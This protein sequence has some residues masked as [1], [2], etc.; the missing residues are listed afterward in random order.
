MTPKEY[1]QQYRDAVRK[2]AAAQDHLDE[3]RSM[4][5]RITPNY[6]SEGGGTH[7]TGDKLGAAVARILDAESRVSDE[8]E[9]LEATERE[10]IGTINSVEEPLRT[11]LYERYINAKTF[12]Q[13]AVSMSYSWRQTIR[14]HGR[15]LLAV[16]NVTECH[17]EKML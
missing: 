10:V 4:A 6:S 17:I 9:M 12:E 8:L 16:K 15:A 1:L 11:L 3:L 7:Q 2:A 13:I 14:L 5:T